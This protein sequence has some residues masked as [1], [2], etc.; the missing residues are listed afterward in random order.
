MRKLVMVAASLTLAAT[1]GAGCASIAKNTFSEP[2]VTFREM[3]LNGIGLTGGSLDI[4]LNVYNPNRFNL[5]GKALTYR[6]M[7]DSVMFGEGALTNNFTVQNGDST[8]VRLPLSFT[9]SGIG[10]AGRQ[11]LNTG[12]VNY[13]VS[14]DITVGTPLGDFKRPYDRTGRYTLMGGAR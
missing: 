9:Y 10:A 12:T 1:A 3:Q 8:L 5:D 11:L 14:G 2:V 4:V 7:I 6:L 13:R